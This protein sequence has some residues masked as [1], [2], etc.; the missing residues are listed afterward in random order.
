[1]ATEQ[2]G[3]KTETTKRTGEPVWIV[4]L[5]GLAALVYFVRLE[6]IHDFSVNGWVWGILAVAI[7]GPEHASH[8][9]RHMRG[10]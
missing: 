3:A 7:L 9:V 8:W 6:A 5:A 4:Q 2:D 1:M 10:R